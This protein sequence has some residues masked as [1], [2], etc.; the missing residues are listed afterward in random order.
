[1]GS[2]I[3]VTLPLIL[4]Q[5]V[6]FGS[7]C[8]DASKW[9]N[10]AAKFPGAVPSVLPGAEIISQE[11][12]NN[13]LQS[14]RLAPFKANVPQ[15]SKSGLSLGVEGRQEFLA[16]TNLGEDIM[17]VEDYEKTSRGTRPLKKSF[18][19]PE[20]VIEIEDSNGQL[21]RFQ[22]SDNSYRIISVANTIRRQQFHQEVPEEPLSFSQKSLKKYLAQKSSR[23]TSTKRALA[24]ISDGATLSP[25]PSIRCP[26]SEV[27]HGINLDDGIAIG[28]VKPP[29]RTYS[30]GLVSNFDW[31]L[32]NI[33]SCIKDQG[34]RG[35]CTAFSV[36]GAM[37]AL[38]TQKYSL[39]ANLSEQAFYFRGKGFLDP[40][41]PGLDGFSAQLY[42]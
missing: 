42:L 16:A 7:G 1:M 11:T 37:E 15:G 5:L 36:I 40:Y 13:Y 9:A 24:S 26:S 38:I 31:P 30:D 19:D 32:K 22:L 35:T 10:I 8:G 25:L 41:S 33:A 12:F 4:T 29:Y 34:I 39:N 27:G 3:S 21:K 23:K 6:F 17:L 20:S 28:G 2:E 18:T 14:G